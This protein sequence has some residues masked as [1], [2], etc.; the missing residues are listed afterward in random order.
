M[1]T[2]CGA[3]C[4]T[5]FTAPGM[6]AIMSEK[7]TIKTSPMDK[8][9]VRM[10]HLQHG[11]S[12]SEIASFLGMELV[13]VRQYIEDLQN[14]LPAPV[15]RKG[16]V[17]VI[18]DPESPSRAKPNPLDSDLLAI[19]SGEVSKR[20]ELAPIFNSI[21]YMFLEK[22]MAGLRD[23]DPAETGR[24]NS[25]ISAYKQLQQGSMVDN[26]VKEQ[27]AIAGNATNNSTNVQVLVFND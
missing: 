20:L 14:S 2:N 22:I 19:K 21:E 4:L 24:I 11:W 27:A 5:Q 7:S 15:S 18:T 3:E 6:V 13:V 25:L 16:E 10:L 17:E 8:M 26:I 12:E 1:I 9:Q 23:I